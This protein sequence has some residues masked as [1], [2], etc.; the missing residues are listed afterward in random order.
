MPDEQKKPER[1]PEMDLAFNEGVNAGGVF[2]RMRH[3]HPKH[4]DPANLISFSCAALYAIIAKGSIP[5]P[6]GK[7]DGE[8][9][10]LL[11]H[12]FAQGMVV[13]YSLA[14]GGRTGEPENGPDPEEQPQTEVKRKPDDDVMYR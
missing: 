2:L 4:S 14:H 12:E 5:A 8:A 10:M 9:K 3:D 1:T 6:D 11:V 7:K 13:A